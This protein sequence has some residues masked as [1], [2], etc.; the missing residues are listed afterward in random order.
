MKS[1]PDMRCVRDSL[2]AFPSDT[3]DPILL[4]SQFDLELDPGNF[5]PYVTSEDALHATS[6]T[7]DDYIGGRAEWIPET[8]TTAILTSKHGEALY[9]DK[10]E[11]ERVF[12][13]IESTLNT[14]PHGLNFCSLYQLAQANGVSHEAFVTDLPKIYAALAEDLKFFTERVRYL[15]G[16]NSSR[17]RKS[18]S[19]YVSSE[20][21]GLQLEIEVA[22]ALLKEVR[23]H[24]IIALQVDPSKGFGVNSLLP[25]ETSDIEDTDSE[26]EAY[27]DIRSMLQAFQQSTKDWMMIEPILKSKHRRHIHVWARLSHYGCITLP[28]KSM[29]LHKDSAQ[30]PPQRRKKKRS[31]I[32][33]T[34]S[35]TSLVPA[36][37]GNLPAEF[38]PPPAFDPSIWEPRDD[39]Q[40]YSSGS[41]HASGLSSY[42][43]AS[44]RSKKRRLAKEARAFACQA[45]GCLEVFDRQCDLAHHERIHCT[46]EE[47]PHACN[48]CDSRFLFPKDLRR[49][50]KIHQK[51]KQISG[52]PPPG[53]DAW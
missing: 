6:A 5:H 34:P 16:S 38:P 37:P 30:L 3:I 27:C 7:S 49:H 24:C 47:R 51:R 2:P 17:L 19:A 14:M 28:C 35:S 41:S 26:D 8:L 13:Q 33:R 11:E 32:L 46:Y 53:L 4:S 39:N 45:D 44:S 22:E 10:A 50:E 9:I 20:A 43:R 18:R 31:P 48:M 21:K 15:N 42:S 23:S 12:Q 36:I 1:V 52:S 25:L 29:F 40:G